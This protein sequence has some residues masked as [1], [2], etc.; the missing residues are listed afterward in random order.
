MGMV[1]EMAMEM[2][3]EMAMAMG[4]VMEMA[5]GIVKNTPE[6]VVVHQHHQPYSLRSAIVEQALHR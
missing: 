4:T 6:L 1:M 5:M 3:M 2:E